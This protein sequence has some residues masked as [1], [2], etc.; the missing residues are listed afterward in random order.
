[1]AATH[2][3]VHQVAG[4]G[5]YQSIT[6]AIAASSSGT[7]ANDRSTLRILDPNLYNEQVLPGALQWL[8]I[9][10]ED[11]CQVR[12]GDGLVKFGAGS[13][14][15]RFIADPANRARFILNPGSGSGNDLFEPVA[16]CS[17]SV[18]GWDF[19]ATSGTGNNLVDGAMSGGESYT[20]RDCD[21]LGGSWTSPIKAALVDAVTL[22]RCDW[23]AMADQTGPV[24][25]SRTATLTINECWLRGGTLLGS[26]STLSAPARRHLVANSILIK[27]TTGT[28]NGMIDLRPAVGHSIGMD[29]W[30]CVIVG[31]GAADQAGYYAEY[32]TTDAKNCIVTGFARGWWTTVAW[33]PTYSCTFDCGA[34]V[35]GSATAGTGCIT[36]DPELDA[37]YKPGESSPVVDTGT[38]SGLTT[39]IRGASRPSGLGEDMGAY[40]RQVPRIL[41]ATCPD[42]N[43][44][45]VTFD[46]DPPASTG[47][48]AAWTVTPRD[49]ASGAEPV[50][51]SGVALNLEA[52]TATLTIAPLEG[53][54]CGAA[55]T[56]ATSS[57]DVSALYRSAVAVV[58]ITTTP[59]PREGYLEAWTG[60]V[61]DEVGYMLSAPSTRLLAALAPGDTEAVVEST[62]HMPDAGTVYIRGERIEYASKTGT[63]LLGLTRETVVDPADSVARPIR[64][65]TVPVGTAVVDGSRT[66]ALVDQVR[67]DL[68]VRRCTGRQLQFRARDLGFPVPIGLMDDA[69]IQD[70]VCTRLY[71]DAGTWWATFRVLDAMFRFAEVTIADG[72]AV[73]AQTLTTT[74][75]PEAG[76]HD[77]RAFIGDRLCRIRSSSYDAGTGTTTLVFDDFDH[78]TFRAPEFAPGAT[79]IAVRIPPFTVTKHL[80]YSPIVHTYLI[81]TLFAG[82]AGLP[83]TYLLDD[84]EATPAGMPIGGQILE[85]ETEAATDDDAHPLYLLEPYIDVVEAILDEILPAA[86]RYEVVSGA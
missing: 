70:Y 86:T 4:Q 13:N 1:M 59:A 49:A 65:D 56:A 67:A 24:V 7:G 69:S 30:D 63:R 64:F 58:P 10:A 18:E 80:T 82:A 45:V 37:E 15:I 36:D 85:D 81:V 33:S 76:Y 75:L 16:G 12:Y 71:L 83:A 19:E 77:R 21:C 51:V 40:E 53:L 50:T 23:S 27:V 14:N 52:D 35:Y 34:E 54:T 73:D 84:A 6:D 48:P 44:V 2:V 26:T 79:G 11:A 42:R 25:T 55:Y 78:P 57:T 8:D 9:I 28:Y 68:R 62:L 20:F 43:T 46:F 74:S 38:L 66:Y 47:N 22:E 39:D 72:V 61:G 60:A 41:S 3:T 31:D 17:F 5:D 32:D 29:L